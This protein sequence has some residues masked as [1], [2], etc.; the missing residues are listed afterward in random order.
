[1]HLFSGKRT[2]IWDWY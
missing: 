2:A 1:M